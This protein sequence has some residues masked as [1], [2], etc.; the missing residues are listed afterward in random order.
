MLLNLTHGAFKEHF[1]IRILF[2][3]QII[4]DLTNR[5]SLIFIK[6]TQQVRTCAFCMYKFKLFLPAESVERL[7]RTFCCWGKRFCACS[8]GWKTHP[9]NAAALSQ[10]K[11]QIWM[12]PRTFWWLVHP[13]SF[14]VAESSRPFIQFYLTIPSGQAFQTHS[15]KSIFSRRAT[16]DSWTHINFKFNR[17]QKLSWPRRQTPHTHLLLRNKTVQPVIVSAVIF[18]PKQEVKEGVKTQTSGGR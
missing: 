16:E 4:L 6:L 8:S 5:F 3:I 13:Q 15:V 10:R 2:Y 17:K 1:V 7:T 18:F 14:R 11:L 9:G 12:I